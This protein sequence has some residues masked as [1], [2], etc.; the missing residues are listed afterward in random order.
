MLL[1]DDVQMSPADVAVLFGV[2]L[3]K[4]TKH[5]IFEINPKKKRL[6]RLNGGH[7]VP[8][9]KNLICSF[10]VVNPNT[11]KSTNIKYAETLNPKQVGNTIIN[12]Y[13]PKKILFPGEEFIMITQTDKAL[14]FFL[15]KDCL[16]S[17]FYVKGKPFYFYLQDKEKEARLRVESK[18]KLADAM[19]TISNMTTDKMRVLAKGIGVPGVDK[20]DD[21]YMLIDALQAIA[22]KDPAKFIQDAKSKNTEFYGTIQNLIDK[23]AI[24]F[25]NLNGIDRW[26]WGAGPLADQEITHV[27]TGQNA[28]EAL[29]EFVVNNAQQYYKMIYD[30]DRSANIENKLDSFLELRQ[31]EEELETRRR[32]VLRK[33][34]ELDSMDRINLSKQ[35]APMPVAEAKNESDEDDFDFNFDEVVSQAIDDVAPAIK[36]DE[37]VQEARPQLP[38]VP[39]PAPKERF[40][41]NPVPGHVVSADFNKAVLPV[42][43][44]QAMEYIMAMEGKRPNNVRGKE[45]LEEIAAGTF[46]PE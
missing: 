14:F 17:P 42:N 5:G 19:V 29:K 23:N 37:P 43:W 16:D 36:P 45:L 40:S 18:G 8:A 30:M 38:Q 24:I 28:F 3:K 46:K 15:S 6:D 10:W 22:E 9:G 34:Q 31:Q 32:E 21:E 2:N 13:Q 39:K 26:F 7:R 44:Q 35:Q 12:E 27:Q 4:I 25:R 11:G 20:M 41:F 33:Q 1:I